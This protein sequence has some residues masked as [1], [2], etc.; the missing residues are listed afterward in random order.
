MNK[1]FTKNILSAA[2]KEEN[3]KIRRTRL[4]VDLTCA[5]LAQSGFSLPEM[6]NLVAVVRKQVLIYFPGKENVFDLIYKPRFQRI[7][8]ERINSN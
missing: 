7:I 5:M 6:L 4:L 2:V 8:R 1:Q 3:R